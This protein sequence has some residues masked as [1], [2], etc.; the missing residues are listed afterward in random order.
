D[1]ATAD[2][3]EGAVKQVIAQGLRT[4]DIWTEGTRKVSCSEMGGAVVAAL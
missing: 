1:P 2:R 4:G 3:I